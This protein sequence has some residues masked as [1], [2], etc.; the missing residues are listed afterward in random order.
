MVEQDNRKHFV[1]WYRLDGQ[2]RYLL[3]WS[4]DYNDAV[5]VDANRQIPVFK[6]IEQAQA[7]ARQHAIPVKIDESGPLNLDGVKQWLRNTRRPVD[8]EVCLTGWNFFVDVAEGTGC[9]FAG[10]RGE[11]RKAWRGKVYDKLFFG[12]STGM[13]LAPEGAPRYEPRWNKTE[14][15]FIAKVLTQGLY[16]FRQHVYLLG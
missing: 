10:Q 9:R 7:F 16:I 15:K 11:T 13:L 14:K 5:W 8:T 3:W 4:G 2:D 12:T 6:T 1:S